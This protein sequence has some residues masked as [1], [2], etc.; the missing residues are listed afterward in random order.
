MGKKPLILDIAEKIAECFPELNGRSIAVSEVDPFDDK[1]N[2]PTLPLAFTALVSEAAEQSVNGGGS[3][4]LTQDLLIQFMHAPVKY[5]RVD[6]A[7]TPF[8]AFYDYEGLRNRLVNFMHGYRTPGNG[9]V[10]Y[11]SMD[12]ESSEYAVHITFRFRATEKW[13]RPE[14]ESSGGLDFSQHEPFELQ[15]VTQVSQPRSN[16][17]CDPCEDCA[18]EDPCEF[19]REPNPEL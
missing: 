12:V 10:Q 17:P 1:T 18:P 15:I 9:G 5:N 4:T 6:G 8:Y 14:L 7:V 19:A 11:R 13:V 2:I 16:K 3:I